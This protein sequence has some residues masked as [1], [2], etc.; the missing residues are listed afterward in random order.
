MCRIG[1]R[2]LDGRRE[3]KVSIAVRVGAGELEERPR[4]RVQYV[5]L[6]GR[7]GGRRVLEP[8]VEVQ[9]LYARECYP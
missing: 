9:L 3:I 8:E 1:Q 7:G 4:R 5:R 2:G 6:K